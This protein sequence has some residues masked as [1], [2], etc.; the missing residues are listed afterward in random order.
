MFYT[1]K[2]AFLDLKAALKEAKN[3][4]FPKGLTHD[5][6]QKCQNVSSFLF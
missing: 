4:N 2:E 6:G 3:P 1:K 5:F